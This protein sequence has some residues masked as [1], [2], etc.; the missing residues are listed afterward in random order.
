M[1]GQNYNNDLQH[2]SISSL[3]FNKIFVLNFHIVTNISS[4]IDQLRSLYNKS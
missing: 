1:S 3:P 2:S 4:T